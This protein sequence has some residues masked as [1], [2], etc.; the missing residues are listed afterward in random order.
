MA[1]LHMARIAQKRGKK[2]GR[3]AVGTTHA[4]ERGELVDVFY[5][6]NTDAE[7]AWWPGVIR[8]FNFQRPVENSTIRVWVLPR[9][10]ENE[11]YSGYTRHVRVQSHRELRH[12]SHLIRGTGHKWP[13]VRSCRFCLGD[14]DLKVCGED[15]CPCTD[16]LLRVR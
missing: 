14:E 10:L 6:A 15:A 12:N 3:T 4:L 16:C 11:A 1:C 9:T 2:R 13:G 7:D 8:D 5:P